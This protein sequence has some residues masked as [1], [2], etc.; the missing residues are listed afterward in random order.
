[1]RTLSITLFFLFYLHFLGLSQDRPVY[2]FRIFQFSVAPGLGTNGLHPGGYING[3]SLNL[4][5]GYSAANHVLEVSGISNLNTDYTKGLQVAGLFNLVGGNAFAG[6]NAKGVKKKVNSGF[7][8][9]LEGL[10]LGGIANVVITNAFGGQVTAGANYVKGGV[11]GLQL[12]GLANVVGKYGFGFQWAGLY[13]S[14]VGSYDGVQ[15][16]SLLNYTGARL[17][18]LQV[19]GLNRVKTIEG[20]K[21]FNYLGYSGVQVGLINLAKKMNGLQVGLVNF[22]GEMQGTQVGLINFYRNGKLANTKDG[23][24]IGLFNIFNSMEVLVYADELFMTNYQ[25]STGTIKNG[26]KLDAVKWIYIQNGIIFG[27]NP[28]LLR[29]DGAHWALGYGLYKKIFNRSATPSM[30]QFRFV[31]GGLEFLHYNEGP[32]L[33]DKLNLVSRLKASAGTRLHPKLSSIYIFGGLSYNVLISR[34]PVDITPG[35]FND[36]H[37]SADIAR[38]RWAG[39]HIGVMIH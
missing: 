27:Y 12:A 9:N 21:S 15:V 11:F 8:A 38:Q 18:G 35:I 37:V 5:S 10:Q 28:S 2:Q 4:T 1:M 34:N 3:F 36:S 13:N 23:T 24:S 20:R 29:D 33:D 6:M 32:G 31:S 17:Q 19:G 26:R 25:L 39:G 22:G 16:A 7:E 14:V 30:N